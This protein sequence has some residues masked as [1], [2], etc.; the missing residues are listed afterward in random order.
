MGDRFVSM[1]LPEAVKA[2]GRQ[3]EPIFENCGAC[4]QRV[5]LHCDNC[6]I[7]VTGCLCTEIDRFGENEAIKRMIDREGYEQTKERLAKAGIVIPKGFN[8]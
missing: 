6:R 8:V 7:Q 4:D 5:A 1:A 2:C 3:Q